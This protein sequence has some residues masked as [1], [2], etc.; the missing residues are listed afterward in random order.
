MQKES[1]YLIKFFDEEPEDPETAIPDNVV[2]YYGSFDEAFY[3]ANEYLTTKRGS[4]LIK[5]E[6]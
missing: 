1:K 4:F 2:E 6:N 5:N 3:F